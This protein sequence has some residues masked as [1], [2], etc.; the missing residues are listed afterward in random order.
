[1][2]ANEVLKGKEMNNF[3]IIVDQADLSNWKAFLFGPDDTPYKNGIFEIK[4]NLTSDY[5]LQPPK[6]YFKTK[7]FHPNILW[8]NGEICLDVIK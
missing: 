8:D 2:E 7:I 5:P 6:V 3:V 4:I 1:M